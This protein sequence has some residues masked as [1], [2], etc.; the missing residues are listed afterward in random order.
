MQAREAG[1]ARAR[2]DP[3]DPS[4]PIPSLLTVTL[5]PNDVETTVNDIPWGNVSSGLPGTEIKIHGLAPAT[6][7]QVKVIIRGFCS[8]PLNFRTKEGDKGTLLMKFPHI[9]ISS[10]LFPP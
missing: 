10:F 2:G 1:M 8:V 6:T 4:V 7:Y 3:A 9:Y 5:T